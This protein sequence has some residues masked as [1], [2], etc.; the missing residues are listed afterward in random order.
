MR[1]TPTTYTTNGTPVTTETMSANF[2]SHEDRSSTT[3]TNPSAARRSLVAATNQSAPKQLHAI[4]RGNRVRITADESGADRF[5]AAWV[6]HLGATVLTDAD[7]PRP[8]DVIVTADDYLAARRWKAGH[9]LA[10]L[11]AADV[12]QLIREGAFAG[13]DVAI[14]PLTEATRLQDDIENRRTA[15]P[16]VL[17][18]GDVTLAA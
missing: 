14:H 2:R 13:L 9:G 1:E 4:G 6:R 3:P 10:Q 15:G 8:A 11:A 12:F 7:S 5:V 17:M 18:P 16:I